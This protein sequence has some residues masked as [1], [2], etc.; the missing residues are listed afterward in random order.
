MLMSVRRE[1]WSVDRNVALTLTGTL[2]GY[3]QQ[4][5]YAGPQF[6]LVLLGI[7]ATVG[8]ILVAIGVFS[9]MAYSVSLQ[10]HEIGIRM[11]LGSPARNV[12]NMVLGKG[13][14]IDWAG[15]CA[16]RDCERG[17]HPA[18]RQSVLG[19]ISQR[20]VNVFRR[21]LRVDCG[22]PGCLPGARAPG[23]ASQSVDCAAL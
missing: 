21:D 23:N 15:H 11:A 3:L 2:E 22:W 13:S 12:L 6:G 1:I 7:F 8:L 9:V 19:R 20:S 10:T 14:A 5:S 17:T 4:F 18:R 16:G